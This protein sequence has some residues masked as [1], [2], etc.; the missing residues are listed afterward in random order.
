MNLYEVSLRFSEWSFAR[1]GIKNL[2]TLDLGKEY[3]SQKEE[4]LSF[5]IMANIK[6]HGYY[7]E[8]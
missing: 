5:A 8:S 2:K 6:L 7:L 1:Q 3:I 4:D